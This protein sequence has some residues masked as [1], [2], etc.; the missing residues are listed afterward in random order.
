[1]LERYVESQFFVVATMTGLGYGNVVPRSNLEYGIDMLIMVTG[2]SI[3]ATFF[4]HF[5]VTIY[6]SNAANIENTKKLEQARRFCE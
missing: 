3:Y 6:N 1:M 4:A 2:A 5:A